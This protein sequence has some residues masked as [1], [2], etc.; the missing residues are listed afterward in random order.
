MKQASSFVV[1]LA[2]VLFTACSS[3]TGTDLGPNDASSANVDP[4]LPSNDASAAE[5]DASVSSNG[6]D[7]G[8]ICSDLAETASVAKVRLLKA[9]KPTPRGGDLVDG[10]FVLVEVTGYE[11]VANSEEPEYIDRIAMRYTKGV[12]E[13]V[14][15]RTVAGKST[16]KRS[17]SDVTTSGVELTAIDTCPGTDAHTFQYSASADEFELFI[18]SG[19]VQRF[20]RVSP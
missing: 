2:C 15:T 19:L 11:N 12:A 5:K 8:S 14:V 17:R 6:G 1:A 20:A 3:S 7:A 9:P 13:F 18:P 10:T 4:A 16:V